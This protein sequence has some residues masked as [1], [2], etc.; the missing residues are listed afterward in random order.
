MSTVLLNLQPD[1]AVF[2]ADVLAGLTARPKTLPCKYFY[3]ERGSRLF[4]AICELPE[5]YLTRTEDWVIKRY[6]REMADQIGPGVMLVEYGSGSSTK[7]RALL[8]ALDDP[9]A[10]VPVDISREHL[11]ATAEALSRAYPEIEILPVCAD[12]TQPFRLPTPRRPPT[13]A[14]VFFPGST[15]GNFHAA[16]VRAM[17]RHLAAMC[18]A[19]GGLL[20]GIDLQKEPSAIEA[21][22][23][24]ARGVTAE[25]NL[26]LLR[27]INRE[28]DADFQLEAFRHRAVYDPALGR[29]EMSLVS[30][31]AQTV[32]IAG[33]RIALARDEAIVTE[34]SHKYTVAGFAGLAAGAGLTL[35][36]TWT[37]ARQQFAVLH[38]ALLA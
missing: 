36:R 29:I 14:A 37:D 23:N 19:G 28:L 6:A 5:Y 16:A 25:F 24:D 13:H 18:G 15:I 4:D 27:R 34:H 20:I 2:L 9:V 26:N 33:C 38:F 31:A 22:Y 1:A 7:T 21:A 3:D 8:D 10:Y 17:L 12:F 11:R 32:S 30:R 35:R